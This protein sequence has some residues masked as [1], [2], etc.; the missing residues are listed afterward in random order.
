[1]KAKS[2]KP[3]APQKIVESMTP[4]EI[5]EY[6]PKQARKLAMTMTAAG[7]HCV[8]CGIAE[9]EAI[10]D[11]MRAHGMDQDYIDGLINEL[12]D[13]VVGKSQGKAPKAETLKPL[14]E[15]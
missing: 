2:T 11:G 7:L 6:F 3:K 5:F 14:S 10:G 8:G 12:N 13:I 9:F 1:M 15:I 4:T